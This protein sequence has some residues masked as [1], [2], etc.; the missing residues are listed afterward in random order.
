MK[1]RFL[2]WRSDGLVIKALLFAAV[3]TLPAGC[4]Y[5]MAGTG[6]LP[7]AIKTIAVSVLNNRTSESGLGIIVSND[8]I[9]ELTRRQK[10]IL[11]S[12]QEADAV[13]SGTIVSLSKETTVRGGSHSSLERKVALNISMSLK[14]NDGRVVWQNS[15]L[16][17]KQ[18]YTVVEGNDSRTEI[19]RREAVKL[20]SQRLAEDAIRQISDN[21]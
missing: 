4:G 6:K 18:S 5:H 16:V 11:A 14:K 19:N 7:G 17:A 8:L 20:A 10:N 3:L 12:Q 13:L 1:K 15:S 21:F 2:Q 9:I